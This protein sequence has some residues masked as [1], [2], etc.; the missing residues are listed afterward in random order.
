MNLHGLARGGVGAVNPFIDADFKSST[1]YTTQ[2]DG[3]RVPTYAEPVTVS[4][5]VQSLTYRDLMQVDG[6]NL[7]GT[8]RAIY[9]TGTANGVVRLTQAG[10][11]IFTI[12]SGPNAGVWLVAM[13]LEQWPDWAKVAVTLQNEAP[14]A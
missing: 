13:V 2:A 8:K 1:G 14:P 7:N 12:S 6:L 4:V 5:Q 10:G 3:I 9:L 11:D